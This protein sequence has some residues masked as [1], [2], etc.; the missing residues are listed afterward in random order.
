MLRVVHRWLRVTA[1]RP[2]WG[3]AKTRGAAAASG[4][5]RTEAWPLSQHASLK[6][7]PCA[8]HGRLQT[9]PL[10]WT[11]NKDASNEVRGRSPNGGG[12]RRRRGSGKKPLWSRN[13]TPQRP[14]PTPGAAASGPDRGP[15]ER[16]MGYS[17]CRTG[18]LQRAGPVHGTNRLC[19]CESGL[20]TGSSGTPRSTT[21]ERRLQLAAELACGI[22]AARFGGAWSCRPG[23]LGC[24]PAKRSPS[25]QPVMG[26]SPG[27]RSTAGCRQRPFCC[28][29]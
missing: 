14:S 20:L 9:A 11:A 29:T 8:A 28:T 6:G 22:G 15:P 7:V 19:S 26:Y 27:G 1:R 24:I 23:G 4:S 25:P 13:H 10:A 3:R 12:G 16:P 18:P 5:L 21:R 17:S 2:A